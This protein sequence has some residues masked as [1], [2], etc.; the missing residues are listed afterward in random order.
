[1]HC[2]VVSPRASD[3]ELTQREMDLAASVKMSLKIL[4]SS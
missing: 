3:S 4:S 1:M 2:L